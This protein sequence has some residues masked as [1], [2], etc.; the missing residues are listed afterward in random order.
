[1]TTDKLGWARPRQII[2]YLKGKKKQE[3]WYQTEDAWISNN[4]LQGSYKYSVSVYI[5]WVDI[6][7]VDDPETIVPPPR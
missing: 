7:I 6:V 4:T 3:K 5:P 1:M 2:P